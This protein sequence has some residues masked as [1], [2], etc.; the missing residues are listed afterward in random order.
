MLPGQAISFTRRGCR[1]EGPSNEDQT[2]ETFKASSAEPDTS[3]VKLSRRQKRT[4][5]AIGSALDDAAAAYDSA[6]AGD[7]RIDES[8]EILRAA[9]S[10]EVFDS[11][12]NLAHDLDAL[13]RIG[14]YRIA[15]V[16]AARDGLVRLA[17][18]Q[19]GISKDAAEARLQA[20]EVDHQV[21]LGSKPIIWALCDQLLVGVLGRSS[22]GQSRVMAGNCFDLAAAGQSSDDNGDIQL[23]LTNPESL[24]IEQD[25]LA[26]FSSAPIAR[27]GVARNDALGSP[28]TQSNAPAIGA[29][30]LPRDRDWPMISAPNWTLPSD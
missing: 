14:R 3:E 13:Y 20:V 17:V 8:I 28:R 30:G 21:R 15:W 4:V 1:G 2:P 16:R 10:L 22:A 23:R 26:S 12:L 7:E 25:Q 11:A 19:Q 24:P 18:E 9:P 5:D 29:I 6:R 27:I